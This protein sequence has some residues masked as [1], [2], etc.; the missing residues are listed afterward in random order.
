MAKA[1]VPSTGNRPYRRRSFP[2]QR[3]PAWGQMQPALSAVEGSVPPSAARREF[4]RRSVVKGYGYFSWA[5]QPGFPGCEVRLLMG[6]SPL[7]G[8]TFPDHCS[9]HVVNL[10]A[11]NVA[12]DKV[13]SV[14]KFTATSW[15]VLFRPGF[16]PSTVIPVPW[17][18]CKVWR[19]R[20]RPR[21]TKN[22]FRRW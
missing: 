9:S 12:Y 16:E 2:Q 6:A 11:R 5:E 15:R 20:L 13:Q 14:V 17:L 10:R 19:G 8:R 18:Q 3:I 1:A 7:R 4:A 22:Q 21:C